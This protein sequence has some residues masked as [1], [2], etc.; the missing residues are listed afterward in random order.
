[1]KKKRYCGVAVMTLTMLFSLFMFQIDGYSAENKVS[2]KDTNGVKL[3]FDTAAMFENH[4]F[5]A[6]IDGMEKEVKSRPDTEANVA[7][8]NENEKVYILQANDGW[9]KIYYGEDYDPGYVKTEGL[10]ICA[11]VSRNEV[12]DARVDRLN[13]V[14][15]KAVVVCDGRGKKL[16]SAPSEKSD[17]LKTF[18]NGDECIIISRELEWT[19]IMFG[20]DE[21]GYIATDSVM[22]MNEYEAYKA[23]LS[24]AK[25]KERTYAKSDTSDG[26]SVAEK[27]LAEG[28]K[29][30]GTRYVYGGNTPSGFDCSGYVQY[31]LKNVGITVGR[32]SR[33]QYKNGVAVERA[34]LQRGDLVFFSQGGNISHVGIY[35]GDGKLLHSPKPGE[36]VCYTTIDRLCSNSTYVGARRVIN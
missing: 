18:A 27:I 10:K 22:N 34:N 25:A 30:I 33:D 5:V 24:E 26:G 11:M 1:M 17:E 6:S 31:V 12:L 3:L 16:M 20:E 4:L 29:Y 13:A 15:Q 14:A 9:S 32:S 28:E 21:V 8:L 2:V 19:K 36:T 35:A 7:V 23:F